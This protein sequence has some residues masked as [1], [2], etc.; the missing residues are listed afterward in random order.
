M[1]SFYQQL[2][3]NSLLLRQDT[4]FKQLR[5]L[6]WAY[7]SLGSQKVAIPCRYPRESDKI[8]F[9]DYERS[10]ALSPFLRQVSW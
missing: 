1:T 5:V 3:H 7:E 8:H 4:H 6:F 9:H 2:Q 10:T